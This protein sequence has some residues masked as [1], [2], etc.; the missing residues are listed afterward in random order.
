MRVSRTVREQNYSS[1]LTELLPTP[2]TKPWL[3]HSRPGALH[4]HLTGH[5]ARTPRAQLPKPFATILEHISRCGDISDYFTKQYKKSVRLSQV[6]EGDGKGGGFDVGSGAQLGTLVF[7][8]R[9]VSKRRKGPIREE[10]ARVPIQSDS[11]HL[12]G[13]WPVLNKQHFYE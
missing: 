8:T 12:L 3:P 9:V 10:T 13:L 6:L 4:V 11:Y 1:L 2:S 5:R 7:A